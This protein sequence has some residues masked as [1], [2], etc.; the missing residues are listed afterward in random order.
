[1][2]DCGTVPVSDYAAQ[3]TDRVTK[4]QPAGLPVLPW[5]IVQRIDALEKRIEVLEARPAV[6][7]RAE[8]MRNYRKK[9]VPAAP[10]PADQLVSDTPPA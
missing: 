7:S 1:M 3:I 5:E 6:K 8:Y 9:V 2:S 10:I 4:E